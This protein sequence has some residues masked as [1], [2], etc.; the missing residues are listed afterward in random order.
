MGLK[1]IILVALF[2]ISGQLTAHSMP[3]VSETIMHHLVELHHGLPI[4]LTVL[5]TVFVTTRILKKR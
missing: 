5:I 2:F 3:T 1:Q 4:F